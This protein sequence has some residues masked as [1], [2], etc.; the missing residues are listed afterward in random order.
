MGAKYKLAAI[1]IVIS[2]TE[3]YGSSFRRFPESYLYI[4]VL[5]RR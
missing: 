2:S 4:F 3:N 1:Y 5:L